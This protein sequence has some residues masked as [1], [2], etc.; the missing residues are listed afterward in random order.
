MAKKPKKRNNNNAVKRVSN[1]L[2]EFID[3]LRPHCK[4]K[5][6]KNTPI[7]NHD[8]Q[9][10]NSSKKATTDSNAIGITENSTTIPTD[11]KPQVNLDSKPDAQNVS[12]AAENPAKKKTDKNDKTKTDGEPISLA[13]GEEQL[14]KQDGILNSHLPFIWQRFYRTSAVEMQYGLGYGWSHSLS[15]QLSF[16]DDHILWRDDENRLVK[17]PNLIH[18]N[19]KFNNRICAA[20]LSFGQNQHEYLVYSSDDKLT[21]VFIRQNFDNFARLAKIMDRHQNTLTIEYN[22]LNQITAISS[23]TEQQSRRLAFVYEENSEILSGNSALIKQ[24][25]LQVKRINQ[26]HTLSVLAKYWYNNSCQ[27]IAVTNAIGDIERYEYDNN[28]VILKRTVP[29]GAEF[30]WEWEKQGKNVRC[31]HQWANYGQLDDHYQ[32]HDEENAVTVT[33]QDGSKTYTQHNNDAKLVKEISGSGY[34]L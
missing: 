32:W 20:T 25:E 18:S 17:F 23:F 33:H 14:A 3:I 30:Y 4:K 12:H 10:I 16:Y 13:T 5:T 28:N 34:T 6:A 7:Q 22:P 11:K 2:N 29:G 9:K 8:E 26:W 19:D 1:D 27:L 15:H 24:V 31:L 21:L